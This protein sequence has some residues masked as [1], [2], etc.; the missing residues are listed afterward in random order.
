[1]FTVNIYT[2]LDGRMG[3]LQLWPERFHRKKLCSRVYS[4]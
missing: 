2:P 4:S 1:M 3:I